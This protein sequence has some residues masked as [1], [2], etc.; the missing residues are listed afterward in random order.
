MV[1]VAKCLG[2][3]RAFARPVRDE[4]I[5]AFLAEGVT[6]GFERGVAQLTV[7]DR[8]DCNFL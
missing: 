1:V 4:A 8:T 6:A 2:T 7:A 3:A 5:D